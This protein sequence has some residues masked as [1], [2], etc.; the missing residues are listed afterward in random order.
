MPSPEAHACTPRHSRWEL[1]GDA[2]C[3]SVLVDGRDEPVDPEALAAALS[4]LGTTGSVPAR[5]HQPKQRALQPPSLSLS[6]SLCGPG[7]VVR[8]T[9]PF[10]CDRLRRSPPSW[11]GGGGRRRQV[12]L[13][14]R[15]VSL[16]LRLGS[17]GDLGSRR[18]PAGR[19]RGRTSMPVATGPV[20]PRTRRQPWQAASSRPT[21]PH[22]GAASALRTPAACS[23]RLGPCQ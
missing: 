20:R 8:A 11:A 6:L 4:V 22:R 19:W 23:P 9:V 13:T 14:L 12:S 15:Q 3:L 18:W 2:L 21:S 5:P 16:T 7:S 17:C 10:S 1:V